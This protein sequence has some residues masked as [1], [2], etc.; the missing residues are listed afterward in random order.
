MRR[1]EERRGEIREREREWERERERESA[2]ARVRDEEEKRGPLHGVPFSVK[3]VYDIIG[4]YSTAAQEHGFASIRETPASYWSTWST[5]STVCSV[6]FA[7]C[8]PIN[9]ARCGDDPRTR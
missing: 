7:A 9:P 3:E 8:V 6:F 2:C 1:G 5:C 4:T